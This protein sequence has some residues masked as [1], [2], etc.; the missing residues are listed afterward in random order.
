MKFNIGDKVL[1]DKTNR[2][3]IIVDFYAD[4]DGED[5]NGRTI[6]IYRPIIQYNDGTDDI[7]SDY[8]LRKV[9][10]DAK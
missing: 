8:H 3:G 1:N 10:C 7:V 9:S 6:Y 2:V 4:D 5:E